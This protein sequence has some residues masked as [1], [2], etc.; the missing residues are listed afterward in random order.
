MDNI[1]AIGVGLVLRAV[2]DNVTHHNFRVNGSLVGLWEGAVLHHFLGKF[3]SSFDPYVAFGFRLFVDLLFTES[4]T[5]TTIVILWTGLGMVLSDVSVDVWADKRIR[6]VW[7]RV[8]PYVPSFLLSTSSPPSRSTSRVQFFE[9]PSSSSTTTARSPGAPRPPRPPHPPPVATNRR[10]S[11]RPIPGSFSEHSEAE[12]E[13]SQAR[14]QARTPSELEYIS[15]PVIP[16]TP[17]GE[18][19]PVVPARATSDVSAPSDVSDNPVPSDASGL[20]TP[21]DGRSPRIAVRSPL[22]NYSGLTT[23]ADARS[24]QTGGEALPP[25]AVYDLDEKGRSHSPTTNATELAPIP[26]PLRPMTTHDNA[27]T[28]TLRADVKDPLPSPG[29]PPPEGQMPN[30]PGPE[31][32][33]GTGAIRDPPPVYEE[34]IAEGPDEKEK[35]KDDTLSEGTRAESLISGHSRNSIIAHADILRQQAIEEEKQRAAL[36]RELEQARRDHDYWK[37]F[38]L[39]VESEEKDQAAQQLHAKAAR[40]YFKAHNMKPEPQTVDVHRLKV[41]EAIAQVERALYDAMMSGAPELRVITGQ[42]NHSKGGIP[43]L[44]LAIVGAM[45]DNHIEAIPDANNAGVLLIRPPAVP[46]SA[47]PSKS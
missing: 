10:V 39:K 41:P 27:S 11:T 35:E 45:Q 34:P 42:G 31:D 3:P 44:K 15:L 8:R 33:E 37:A 46:P 17:G 36:R 47:G 21:L 26:I 23:P 9:V 40:R 14:Q 2:I 1:F 13:V 32:A 19:P 24:P 43:R 18:Y 20:T 16:D 25:V 29:I 12:T 30:I 28:A 5:Q 22:D 6:R 38:R 7:R 4:L